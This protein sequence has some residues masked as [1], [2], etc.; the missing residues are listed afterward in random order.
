MSLA[1]LAKIGNTLTG[2]WGKTSTGTPLYK[3]AS[4]SSTVLAQLPASKAATIL[5]RIGEWYRVHVGGVEGWVQAANFD[6]LS[7]SGAAVTAA[8]NYWTETAWWQKALIIG[9]GVAGA[10]HG[11]QRDDSYL[12]AVLWSIFGS[13]VPL[14][15][16]PIMLAQGLGQR[17]GA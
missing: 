12:W 11:Y 9:G 14:L 7:T 16:L 3:D 6:E 10:Y 4:T 2:Q 5:G 17:K 13:T 8:G 15:A 1:A